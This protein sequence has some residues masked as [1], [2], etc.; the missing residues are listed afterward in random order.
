MKRTLSLVA[1]GLT[2]LFTLSSC[3]V[4]TPYPPGPGYP[5]GGPG[6]TPPRPDYRPDD[7]GEAYRLGENLGRED[8]RDR[9]SYNPERYRHRVSGRHWSSFENGYERGYRGSRPDFDDHRPGFDDHRPDFG[10]T[11]SYDRE[12]YEDGRRLGQFDRSRGLSNDYRRHFGRYPMRYEDSFRR[13][14][15]KGWY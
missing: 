11:G 7:S 1:V 6:V 4:T 13:G 12:T 3:I 5:P 10:G 14:Y 2:A 15:Q 9:R 8:R